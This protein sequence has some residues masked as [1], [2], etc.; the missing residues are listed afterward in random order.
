MRERDL[1]K[2]LKKR[3]KSLRKNALQVVLSMQPRNRTSEIHS[4]LS[5]NELALNNIT[6]HMNYQHQQMALHHH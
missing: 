3:S 6:F 1:A 4:R 5:E 2:S